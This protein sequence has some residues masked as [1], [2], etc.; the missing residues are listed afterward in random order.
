VKKVLLT[1]GLNIQP[2]SYGAMKMSWI[3]GDERFRTSQ[4][5]LCHGKRVSNGA[6][7]GSRKPSATAVALPHADDLSSA[8]RPKQQSQREEAG[9]LGL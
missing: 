1:Q 4:K 6:K 9:L 2:E 3:I 7:L 8:Q 5:V